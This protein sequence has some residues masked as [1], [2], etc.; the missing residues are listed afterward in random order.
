MFYQWSHMAA[1][2]VMSRLQNWH[3]R[4]FK[5]GDTIHGEPWRAQAFPVV[6]ELVVDRRRVRPGSCRPADLSASIPAVCLT[7]FHPHPQTDAEFAMDA[8]ACSG[9]RMCG[10]CKKR[11][12]IVV[13]RCQSDATVQ[14][15]HRGK[16]ERRERVEKMMAAMEAEVCASAPTPAPVPGNVPILISQ[17]TI[18][19]LN[20]EYLYARS[21]GRSRLADSGH[22][23]C[24][25]M[26][27][28]E[29]CDR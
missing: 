15:A 19:K 18:A 3:M 20:R 17:T 29:P 5:N 22:R 16:T 27:R 10:N 28:A 7:Q 14:F 2:T 26:Y 6:K 13:C 11:I 9:V 12:G 1:A 24:H 4:S 8:A 23:T 21:D 25:G